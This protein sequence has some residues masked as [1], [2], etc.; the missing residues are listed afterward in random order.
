MGQ[1][2][3]CRHSH[4]GHCTVCYEDA[5]KQQEYIEVPVSWFEVLKEM[6]SEKNSQLDEINLIQVKG[7]LSSVDTI[8]KYNKRV[9]K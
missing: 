6:V 3:V 1:N 2:Y 4:E 5:K 8:L 9:K 7:Y